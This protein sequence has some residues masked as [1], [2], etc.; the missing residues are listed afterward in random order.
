MKKQSILLLAFAIPFL[1]I[2][3]AAS[4]PKNI[5]LFSPKNK[6]VS[7]KPL[8]LFKGKTSTENQLF[9]N[10]EPVELTEEGRF[11]TKK[12]LEKKHDYNYFNLTLKKDGKIVT[13]L[14]RKIFYDPPKN[15]AKNSNP[16]IEVQIHQDPKPPYGYSAV[17][18]GEAAQYNSIHI[19]DKKIKLKDSGEF[20]H[21]VILDTEKKN[22]IGR[23]HV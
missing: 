8:V 10:G 18:S 1:G 3:V 21:K 4:T 13:L 22:E 5:I 7:I 14:K 2:K 12:V 9:I 20:R 15:L 6:S 17:Y 19:R 11:Y 16:R 23:A